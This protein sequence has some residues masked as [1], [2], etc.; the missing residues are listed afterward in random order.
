MLRKLSFLSKKT[1][2]F[3]LLLAL[4]SAVCLVLLFAPFR[5][6]PI[7]WV[8]LLPVFFAIDGENLKKTFLIGYFFGVV[9]FSG[10]V[11]WL[12]YVTG[13][14]TVLLILYLSVYLCLFCFSI[15]WFKKSLGLNFVFTAPIA[16]C[17]SEYMLN[18]V[19]T[20]FP[21]DNLG[22]A[23]LP[24]PYLSQLAQYSG[25]AGLSFLLVLGNAVV[26]NFVKTILIGRKGGSVY[27]AT[28]W[29]VLFF[30]II[31]CLR[32]HGRKLK[33]RFKPDERSECVRI[34]LLQAN[35]SQCQKWD[36]SFKDEIIAKYK[37]LTESAAKEN[38]DLIVWSESSLPGFFQYDEKSTYA[39]FSLIKELKIPILFG[40]NRLKIDKGN[41]F[42]Y[43]SA[44]YVKPNEE[45]VRAYDKIHLVPYGEYIPNRKFLKRLFPSLESVVPFEDFSFGDGVDIFDIKDFKFGVSICFEDIFP[46]LI[47]NIPKIGADFV[48]NITNDAWYMKSGAPYQHFDMAT[49]RAI[50]NRISYVRCSN[51]GV[52]GYVLPDGESECFH[53]KNGSLI[54]EE[55]FM[56][57]KVPKNRSAVNTFY[58]IHGDL[59][60]KASFNVYL[61]L[62]MISFVYSLRKFLVRR[63][64]NA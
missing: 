52:T 11:Y 49:L 48:L 9:F 34:A 45:K 47:R 5:F 23:F 61:L 17:F 40:G 24:D 3:K 36:E 2:V 51:T 4:L 39:V 60:G 28:V 53:G 64:L 10:L 54:F 55:G 58:T 56:I 35:I 12:V 22:Y 1:M 43:N 7:V 18:S 19:M 16:W 44:Y 30:A 42:Y 33:D 31:F 21:W 32:L 15:N 25:V 46:D 6:Y 27:Y 26:Y 57:A 13:I 62:F 38:P 41:Y 63:R 29:L 14:G 20:G 50:E 37:K 8:V 59:I